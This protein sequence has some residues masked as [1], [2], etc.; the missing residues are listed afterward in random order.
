M[1][2]YFDTDVIVHYI[3]LQDKNK[4]TVARQLI[5]QAI[6]NNVFFISTLTYQELAF[7]LAKLGMR[8]SSIVNNLSFFMQLIIGTYKKTELIRADKIAHKVG[9]RN[10][11][12]C[13]HTA[14]AEKH[15]T[16]LITFNKKDFSTIKQYS[17]LKITIL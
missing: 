3:I 7:V 5:K 15:C 1:M 10:I 16:E 8:E 13:I 17:D 2:L 4:Q 12:D 11:N 9:Y 6:E 14:I